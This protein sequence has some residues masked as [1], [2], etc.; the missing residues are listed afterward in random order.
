[1]GHQCLL[2]VKGLKINMVEEATYL[3]R[4]IKH[5]NLMSEKYKRHVSI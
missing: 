3:S 4:E 1:M 5:H 2:G